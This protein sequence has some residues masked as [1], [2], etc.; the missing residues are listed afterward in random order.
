MQRPSLGGW[1]QYKVE[2]LMQ[3]HLRGTICHKTLMNIRG[4][5]ESEGTG[6]SIKQLI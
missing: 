1:K 2:N 4:E 6:D 3:A 5:S